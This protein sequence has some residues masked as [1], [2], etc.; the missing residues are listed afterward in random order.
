M[1]CL[2]LNN[3]ATEGGAAIAMNRLLQTVRRNGCAAALLTSS[4]GRDFDGDTLALTLVETV[5]TKLS[6]RLDKELVD[7]WLREAPCWWSLNLLPNIIAKRISACNPELLHLHWVGDGFLPLWNIGRFPVP[8]IWTLHDGWAFTGGC[9][10]FLDCEKYMTGC[11]QCP[12]IGSCRSADISRLVCRLKKSG[13]AQHAPVIVTPSRWLADCA[14]KSSVLSGCRVE[15]IPNG[16]DT[17]VFRPLDKLV[18]RQL[19]HLP[20]N[21]KIILCGAM[22]GR[23]NPLKGNDLF[24]LSLRHLSGLVNPQEIA[25]ASFGDPGSGEG[26]AEWSG[27]QVEQCG[28]FKD[29][30][31]LALLYSAADV[32]VQ[33]SLQDNLPNTVM[34]ALACGT[35]VVCFRS[36]GVVDMVEHGHNGYIAEDFSPLE[37]ARGIAAILASDDMRQKLSANAR[38]T[39]C[40]SFDIRN[41]AARY[42]E[43]YREVLQQSRAGNGRTR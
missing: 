33:P 22:G 25:V 1:R 24:T 29:E 10:T 13:V 32:F 18:A 15:T 31:S 43:L 37:L 40:R 3:G 16:V 17:E 39:V 30:L 28:V 36:G 11:G 8:V 21:K 9:H 23:N 20:E 7:R 2:F 4:G 26:T 35:P 38:A 14:R 6:A 42:V 12:Q 27:F 34:E 5:I 19:L 41:V